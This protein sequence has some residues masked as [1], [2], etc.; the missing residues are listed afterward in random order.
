MCIDYI[1]QAMNFMFLE[2]LSNTIYNSSVVEIN[3]HV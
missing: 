2:M 3:T 1:N